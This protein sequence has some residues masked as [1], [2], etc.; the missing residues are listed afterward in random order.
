MIMASTNLTPPMTPDP[1]SKDPNTVHEVGVF[2]PE[3]PSVDNVQC[4]KALEDGD[5]TMTN[6]TVDTQ[7]R[8]AR[9]V[10]DFDGWF[11]KA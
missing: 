2:R 3:G 5:A 1:K 6:D 4:A 9:Y 7:A 11:S 10:T 8:G